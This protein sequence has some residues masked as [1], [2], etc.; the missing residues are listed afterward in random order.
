MTQ[1]AQ[2]EALRDQ[3]R[4][5]EA[6]EDMLRAKVATAAAQATIALSRYV[7]FLAGRTSRDPGYARHRT[8][9]TST[10]APVAAS[11]WSAESATCG[12]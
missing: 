11:A 7:G 6:R 2:T 5:L 3:G 10:G 4:V 1:A 9:H 8:R 12:S